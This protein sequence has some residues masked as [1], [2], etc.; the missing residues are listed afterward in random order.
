MAVLKVRRGGWRPGAVFFGVFVFPLLGWALY[1]S[2]DA[3]LNPQAQAV[4]EAKPEAVPDRE[5]LFLALL[6]FPIQGDERAHE[7]GAAALAAYDTLGASAAA[8]RTG[9]AE[10]LG[11][12][13]AR[14]ETGE[15]RLCSLGNSEGAYQC[16][17]SSRAQRAAFE[18]LL[19]SLA[20]LLLRYR[21]LELYPR[22]ADPRPSPPDAGTD[23]AALRIA[24]LN[25]SVIAL[26]MDEGSELAGLQ[27]LARSAAIWRRVLAARDANLVDK[28]VASRLYAAHLLFASELIRARRGLDGE[29]AAALESILRPLGEAERSLV[30]ALASEFRLQ[31]AMWAQVAD[32]S[33]EVVRADLPNGSSWWYRLLVKKNDSINRS[34]RSTETLLELERS[35]C[36]AV[37][38]E[39]DAA[40]ARPAKDGYGLRWYEWLYNPI[41]R[42]LHGTTDSAQSLVEMLGRQC[43]LLALQGM[44]AQQFEM[45]RSGAEAANLATRHIDPNSGGPYVLDAGARTLSY[46]FIG[47][48]PE[49][50]TPLPLG[51]E[52]P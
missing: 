34:W 42:V 4:L 51:P 52:A 33:S 43:N 19:G 12:M 32:P 10:A 21:E 39:L 38:R 15:A 14:V 3:P 24:Q 28:M 1:N 47:T 5:N 44:V 11:R 2:W 46:A 16:I 48:R 50:T 30:G 26:A 20:P 18:P 40:A 41:G 27:A 37:R 35:G 22:Y 7:R 9:Y 17:E 49:F 6:A 23:A 31:A 8:N 29:G 13:S 45:Q 36:V 25:L